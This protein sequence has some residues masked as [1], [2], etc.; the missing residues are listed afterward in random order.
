[1]ATNKK[2][3]LFI[4]P[5]LSK[6]GQER[7][8][9]RLSFAL[10]DS[11]Y[12]KHLVLFYKDRIDY[13]FKGKI[14]SLDIPLPSSSPFKIYRKIFNLFF[15]IFNLRKI[16]KQ[17]KPDFAISF[18]P[19]ANIVNV[20]S[21]F[22]LKNV[23]TIVSVRVIESVHFQ[24]Y[25]FFLRWYYYFIMKIV[26]KLAKIIVPNSRAIADDLIK[27]FH[28][29][30]EKI[31]VINNFYNLEEIEKLSK[32]PM[33]EF[34]NLF[35]KN[36]VIIT[37]GRLELQKDHQSLI[38]AFQNV[39][40]KFKDTILV[41]LG[42]GELE[43]RLKKL[44][45]DLNLKNSVFFLGFQK[46]PFK[47]FKNSQIFILPSLYEGFPNVLVEAMTCGLPVIATDCPGGNKE[48][49]DPNS[50][51]FVRHCHFGKFGI[52]VPPKNPEEI[53]K[54]VSLLLDNEKLRKEYSEKAKE[55]T[56]DFS[57]DKII[58][59]WEAMLKD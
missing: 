34:E 13:P 9:S 30:K 19:E 49:L 24:K 38:R 43:K 54:A 1:M 12:E 28:V 4:L 35:L 51:E 5:T 18:G 32:E 48:I 50:S 17:L 39:K 58:S 31:L 42:E 15:R 52:L 14:I 37:A 16:K 11:I 36:K 45:E 59:Q 3:I 10:D 41:I 22:G 53:F 23:K 25:P 44:V 40:E 55:R 7:I 21:N 26:Y 57:V 33:G 56:K 2:R 46:N 27:N 20:F 47:F 8:V 29:Q 6:G